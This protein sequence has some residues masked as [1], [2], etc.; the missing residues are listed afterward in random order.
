MSCVFL[1]KRN[2]DNEE[3]IVKKVR[4]WVLFDDSAE[5]MEGLCRSTHPH[6]VQLVEHFTE[7]GF[8]YIVMEYMNGG[9]LR[10]ILVSREGKPITEGE[11]LLCFCPIVKG[12]AS[13]HRAGICH[14][15]LIAENIFLNSR[16]VVKLGDF[17]FR[18]A[19]GETYERR[20][21]NYGATNY[22]APELLGGDRAGD[23]R[24]DVWAL[25]CLLYEIVVLRHP[26]AA[27]S[28]LQ[29][30]TNV[31]KAQYPPLPDGY[32]QDLRDL[33]AAMLRR[34]PD[35]RISAEEVMKLEFLQPLLLFIKHT[36]GLNMKFL[37]SHVMKNYEH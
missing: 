23:A 3:F 32:S 18:K 31:M 8:T 20:L 5:V 37:Y 29:F 26:F 13:M 33:I 30:V 17:G 15:K 28:H 4:R 7:A 16:N 2:T 11:A 24:S 25:G 36:P 6:V 21:L 35:E 1:V 27:S 10:H 12:L 22:M 19:T 14:R 9:T 34:D